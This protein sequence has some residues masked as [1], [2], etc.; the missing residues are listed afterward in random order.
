MRAQ[1][2]AQKIPK[3][4]SDMENITIGPAGGAGGNIKDATDQSFMADVIEASKEAPVLV[5]FWAPWCGPCKSLTPVLEKVVN[6]QQGK[7]KLVKVNIDENPGVAGQLGVRSI[8]AVFAFENGRPVDAFQGALPEG[9]LKQFVEKLLGGTDEGQQIQ[10]AIEHADK[11]LQSGDAGQAAQIYSAIIERDQKNIAAIAGLARCYLAN[12]DPDRAA[13]ILDMAGPDRQMD[14]AIKSVRTAI[15]LM[16]DA[17]KDSE[18]DELMEKVTND[19]SNHALRFELAEELM[20]RGKNKEAA[21]HLLRILSDDL[22]WEEGK[23]KAKLLELF[24]AAG[25]KDPATIE[26]RRRL[27]SLMFA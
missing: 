17:P 12:D 20:A 2:S 27:S 26:G 21:D 22:N 16:A 1:V 25:P 13:Q 14:P 11:L 4:A 6:E 8:P 3:G 18:L 9:Q 10:E 7:V 19:R 15:E 24:E 5:D 23:A